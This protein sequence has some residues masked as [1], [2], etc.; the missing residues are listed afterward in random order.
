MSRKKKSHFLKNERARACHPNF[1]ISH[2]PCF[3]K[4]FLGFQPISHRLSEGK[5]NAKKQLSA[6]STVSTEGLFHRLWK[7]RR[8]AGRGARGFERNFIHRGVWITPLKKQLMRV[9]RLF[10]TGDGKTMKNADDRCEKN[11]RPRLKTPL[12]ER[13]L[14][15]PVIREA[16]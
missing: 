2:F 13:F 1:I 6:V 5:K 14:R 8:A 7:T 15:K 4:R 12:R 10:R 3:F 9:A 16:P 11:G